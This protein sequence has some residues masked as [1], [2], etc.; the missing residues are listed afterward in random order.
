[1]GKRR[2]TWSIEE[3]KEVLKYANEYGITKASREYNVS[4]PSIC[5]WRR[6]LEEQ[7]EESLI[8]QNVNDRELEFKRLLKENRELKALVA[9]KELA[10]RIKDSLLKKFHRKIQKSDGA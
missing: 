7:G 8:N 5:K 10:L 1:M 2:K 3:K 9:E 6:G 4:T